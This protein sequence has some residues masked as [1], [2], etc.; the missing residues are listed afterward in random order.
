MSTV[1]VARLIEAAAARLRGAGVAK[2]RR[3]A[4]RLW[5]WQNRIDPG[6]S[7][8]TRERSPGPAPAR[9]FEAAVDRRVRGK[10]LAYVL[11]HVGFRRLEIR[12][13]RRALIPRPESEGL[14]ELALAHRRTGRVLDL[15]TGTG[16][17]ALALADEGAFSRIVGV[18][19]SDPALALARENVAATGLPVELMRIDLG[20]ALPGERFDLLVANPPY[21]SL[22]E[23]EMLDPSVRDWE[24]RVALLAG[25]DGMEVAK[26]ILHESGPLLD[27]GGVLVMEVDSTRARAVAALAAAAGWVDVRI[28]R[29]LFGRDRYL[30]ACPGHQSPEGAGA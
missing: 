13:D 19:C 24:P 20:A 9:A 22:A 12:C 14:V 30:T 25:S 21:V 4:N 7:Y 2:P 15:G 28:G 27:A 18:D 1:T 6:Q 23:Y 8:L 5:A 29:D 10:P 17:L 16:C 3:E 11:G 26:R